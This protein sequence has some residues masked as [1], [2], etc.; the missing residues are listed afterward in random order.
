MG[1]A[2]LVVLAGGLSS[3]FGRDKCTYVYGGRRLIDYVIEAGRPVAGRVAI[4]A[5]RNAALYPGEEVVEDSPRFSGPLAAVDSAVYRYEGPLLFAPCDTPFLKPAA[6][7]GLLAARSPLAVWV[8]PS[9][10]VESAVF[11]AEAKAARPILDL[12]ARFGRGR[13]DDLF[14]VGET[15]FLSMERHGVDPAWFIN[16]NKPADLEASAAVVK[17]RIYAEDNVVS[18]EE[19]PLVKWLMGGGLDPLRRELLRYLELGL[20]SMAAH[21]AKDLS[22]FIPAYEALAEALYEASGVEKAR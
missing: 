2:V 16:V 12:L 10:R 3:R 18:W 9:G 7:E 14:R 8:Y 17:R 22:R 15:A 11:K 5:G 1:G 21:V 6:F 13:I 20:F 4:A 19:P